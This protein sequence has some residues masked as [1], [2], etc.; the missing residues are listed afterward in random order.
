MKSPNGG[1]AANPVNR[2]ICGTPLAADEFQHGFLAQT[3]TYPLYFSSLDA[4]TAYRSYLS[5][6]F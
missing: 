5:M 6:Y 4:A 2:R 1:R 3:I